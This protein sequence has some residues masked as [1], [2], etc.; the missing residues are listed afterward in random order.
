MPSA[1]IRQK[2]GGFLVSCPT[3]LPATPIKP[4]EESTVAPSSEG[5]PAKSTSPVLFENASFG[6]IVETIAKTYGVKARFE[7]EA[8]KQ[9]HL[10]YKFDP[11]NTLQNIVD[12][13]NSF[14]QIDMTLE[15]SELVVR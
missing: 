8:K 1:R 6:E 11:N 10:F 13:L 5:V 4:P 15:G 2:S 12:Q 7:A 9:L 3:T 14:E